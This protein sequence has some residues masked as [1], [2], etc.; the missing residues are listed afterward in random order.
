MGVV[1]CLNYLEVAGRLPPLARAVGT[2]FRVPESCGVASETRTGNRGD[3]H[4][5]SNQTVRGM[6]TT[7]AVHGHEPHAPLQWRACHVCGKLPVAVH[8]PPG[9]NGEA[10]C[11]VAN[12]PERPRRAVPVSYSWRLPEPPAFCLFNI[13]V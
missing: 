3:E 12:P 4:H 8:Y 7:T 11:C 13:A 1:G 5:G 2:F 9:V 10:R 6:M